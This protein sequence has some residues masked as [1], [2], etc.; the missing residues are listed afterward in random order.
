MP[1]AVLGTAVQ[2]PP[3]VSR[4]GV[5]AALVEVSTL[6]TCPVE[7]VATMVLAGGVANQQSLRFVEGTLGFQKLVGTRLQEYMY[8]FSWLR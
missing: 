4:G 3:T 6:D 2:C 8:A 7:A 1:S 5:Y